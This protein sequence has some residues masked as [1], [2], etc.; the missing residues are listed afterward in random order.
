[1]DSAV[2]EISSTA[3]AQA[4]VE[5]R[6]EPPKA[7]A[8]PAITCRRVGSL[9]SAAKSVPSLIVVLRILVLS[10]H[11]IGKY[12]T[13]ND[14]GVRQAFSRRNKRSAFPRLMAFQSSSEK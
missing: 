7:I 13:G 2:C 14:G 6:A 8:K 10:R 3:A 11:R 4:L 5:A 1:M 12:P 9:V